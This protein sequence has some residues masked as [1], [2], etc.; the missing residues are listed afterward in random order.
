VP[1]VVEL[2]R[3]GSFLAVAAER[4]E[5]AIAALEALR[6]AARWVESPV[7]RPQDEFHAWMQSTRTID[8]LI[9]DGRQVDAPIPPPLAA[10]AGAR[11]LSATYTK[12][13]LMHG[14]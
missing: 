4:E 10:P 11:T 7:R 2:V 6:R 5:Q 8:R 1:G 9:D 3:D 13:Y 14:A 12:P